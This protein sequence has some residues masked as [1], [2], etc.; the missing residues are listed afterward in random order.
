MRAT[1]RT[2]C[3]AVAVAFP[4]ALSAQGVTVQS[5][6][7]AK[8]YGG[9]GTIVNMASRFGGGSMHD[10]QTTTSISGHRM[11][12]ETENSG[13]IIDADAGSFT[14]IDE[15]QKTYSTM[16][17]AQLADAMAQ[18]QANAKNSPAR[19]Q[20]SAPAKDPN[21]SKD[22]VSVKYKVAVERTGQHQ[23]VAGY[24]AE[25][26]FITI[27]LEG[28]ATPQG[29]QTQQVGSM[30]FLLDQWIS[31]DAPQLAAMKEFQKAYMT[32]AGGV[33][34]QQVSSMNAVFAAD[35]RM[36]DGMTAAAKEMEKVGG[37]S[38][39]STTY[40][41]LVP[42]QLTF[43]RNKALADAAA[44]NVADEK[45]K[46]EEASKP[47][48]SRFGGMMGALKAAAEKSA[49][50]S[51]GKSAPAELTQSTLMAMSDQ[52]TSLS[53]GAVPAST[54]EIPAGYREVKSK[55]ASPN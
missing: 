27:T 35:P 24:D 40:A 52:V 42:P 13:T 8:F 15:K 16:T 25:R 44:G 55:M 51:S 11:R 23:K 53:T 3:I 4:L 29:E 12:V 49:D 43:D 21:A 54:F 39:R 50:Q 22:S 48:Q 26:V 45:A 41:V 18:A 30:V 33:F 31:K 9:L 19:Q 20:K 37:I 46:A 28:E 38:L 10:K 36:K 1:L 6:T 2:S 17:F 34:R 32:K 7:D 47:K 5:V 14:T